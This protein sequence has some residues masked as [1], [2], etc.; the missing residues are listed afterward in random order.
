MNVWLKSQESDR[1]LG[2]RPVRDLRLQVC[3]PKVGV[4]LFTY[5]FI[6]RFQF[7]HAASLPMNNA[8]VSS[9]QGLI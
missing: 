3:Q 2:S 4:L 8:T 5:L 1:N 6:Y 9:G 7:M